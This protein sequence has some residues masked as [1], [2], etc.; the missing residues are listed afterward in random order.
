MLGGSPGLGHHRVAIRVAVSIES[1]LAHTEG[2]NP[3]AYFVAH[4]ALGDR[5]EAR[6]EDIDRALYGER[7]AGW[8]G[9]K[10]GLGPDVSVRRLPGNRLHKSHG[11]RQQEVALV[12]PGHDASTLRSSEQRADE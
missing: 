7:L 4:V 9:F 5:G 8:C 10:T 6:R 2:R 11:L 12:F 1:L 3:A